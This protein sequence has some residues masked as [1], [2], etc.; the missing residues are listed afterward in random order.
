MLSRV[1]G[2]E[3]T[4]YDRY[5]LL[6]VA[7]MSS[8]PV[9]FGSLPLPCHPGFLGMVSQGFSLRLPLPLLGLLVLCKELH[10]LKLINMERFERRFDIVQQDTCSRSMIEQIE[11]TLFLISV[12]NQRWSLLNKMHENFF[13]QLWNKPFVPQLHKL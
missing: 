10:S 8:T 1:R 5:M 3:K 9:I 12:F 11:N 6:D 7:H 2:V 4:V 13:V